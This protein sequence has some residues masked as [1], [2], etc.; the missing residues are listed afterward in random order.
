MT[1]TLNEIKKMFPM[2]I[3]ISP[4]EADEIL[5]MHP[6]HVRRLL[7]QEKLKGSHI[8]NQWCISIVDLAEAIDG[9]NNG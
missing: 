5:G 2:R 7:R 9:S 8:G 3:S 1:T 6:A 4:D